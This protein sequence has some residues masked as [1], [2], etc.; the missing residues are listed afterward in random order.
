LV[1]LVL[2]CL[3]LPALLMWHLLLLSLCCLLLCCCRLLLL[4]LL[5]VAD[6]TQLQA[7]GLSRT[8][9]WSPAPG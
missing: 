9:L 4:W 5:S 6:Q 8:L 7:Q 2:D 3:L 1:V